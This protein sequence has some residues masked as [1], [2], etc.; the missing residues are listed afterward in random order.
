MPVA[1]IDTPVILKAL[2]PVWESAP[3]T[4]SRLRKAAQADGSLGTPLQP[5]G[6]GRRDGYQPSSPW[7]VRT[8]GRPSESRLTDSVL[9][10]I[11]PHL[12][13][14]HAIGLRN[15]GSR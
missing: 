15:D 14:A 12:D 2:Q 13:A 7:R 11:G 5:A 10:R 8:F 3:E 4:G 9:V 6:A 1:M